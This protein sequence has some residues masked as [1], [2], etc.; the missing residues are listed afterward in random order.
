MNEFQEVHP[1][2][3]KIIITITT[4]SEEKKKYSIGIRHERPKPAAWFAVY[5][6]PYGISVETIQLGGIGQPWNPAPYPDCF[7]VF[8]AAD[9]T[10]FFSH[11]CTECKNS[12]RSKSAPDR[13]LSTCPYCGIKGKAHQFLTK[14]QCHFVKACCDMFEKAL[15]EGTDGEHCID[16]DEIADAVNAGAEKPKFFYVEE[17]QQNNYK[18]DA[19]GDLQDILGQFGYC[20]CCGTLNTWQEFSTKVIPPIRERI[21]SEGPYEACVRDVVSA[22]DSCAGKYVDQLL[23]HI[24]LTPKRKNRIERIPFHNL[25]TFQI[26][27]ESIF[28]IDI[29]KGLTSEEINFAKLM[30]LRRHVYEHKGGEADEIYIKESGDTTVKLKQSLRETQGSANQITNHVLKMAKNLHQ[31]FHDIFPPEEKALACLKFRGK[32]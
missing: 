5:A 28:G 15:I 27:F 7:P 23:K 12:W 2:G 20:S 9:E 17:T 10:G 22:F 29:L 11:F 6:L 8:I 26:E 16:M 25:E 4:D 14:G 32:S 1:C 19:C 18:C 3:G 24:P 21:N 31:G 13:W 30:F